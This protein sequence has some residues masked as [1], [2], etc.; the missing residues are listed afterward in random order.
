VK[1]RLCLWAAA[2]LVAATSEAGAT[3]YNGS[4]VVDGDLSDF[5]ADEQTPGDPAGDSA[6]GA[7]NDLSGLF[8]TWDKTKLYIGAAYV[9]WGTGVMLLLEAGKSGGATDLCSPGYAGA[10]PANVQGPGFDLLVGWYVS[11][12]AATPTPFVFTLGQS[13]STDITTQSG[14][15]I[16]LKET[17][18]T[19]AQRHDGTLELALPWEVLYGL[20]PGK[21][22]AGVKLRLVVALRGK[23][24]GDGLGDVSPDQPQPVAPGSCGS[25]ASNL[26][27]SFHEVTVDQDGDGVPEAGWSPGKNAP[28]PSDA[29]VPDLSTPDA[30]TP[31]LPPA[32]DLAPAGDPSPADLTAPDQPPAPPGEPSARDLAPK[33][34]STVGGDGP[35]G[36]E[37]NGCACSAKGSSLTAATLA[38]ALLGLALVD[39]RRC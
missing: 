13:S 1:T 21:V 12:T 6:Y 8:I 24:D 25:G 31:D 17:V 20:G 15:A 33:A 29:G 37:G 18:D 5:A 3:T 10:F 7:N 27:A 14:V 32:G 16:K 22:P 39:R 26:L 38:L 19:T 34:D 9:A 30:S 2:L 28:A 23:Q 35:A 36:E 4:I 11:D